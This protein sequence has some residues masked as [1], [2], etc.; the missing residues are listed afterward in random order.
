MDVVIYGNIY[1]EYPTHLL[2]MIY[3]N[4]YFLVS[5]NGVDLCNN[6]NYNECDM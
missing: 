3:V 2:F 5:S 1:M 4:Y 6:Y